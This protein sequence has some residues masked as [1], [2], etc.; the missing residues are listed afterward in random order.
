MR[1]CGH[2]GDEIL[3][4]LVFSILRISSKTLVPTLETKSYFFPEDGDSTFLQNIDNYLQGYMASYP[5]R[6]QSKFS[7]L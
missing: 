1:L 3:E 6:L 4:K 5:R 2:V 7:L